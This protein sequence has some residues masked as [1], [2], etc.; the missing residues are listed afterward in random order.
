M[1]IFNEQRFA[2]NN[3]VYETPDDLFIPLMNEFHF[4]LDVCADESNAK[5][6]KFFNEEM[7]GLNQNWSGVCW[8]NPPFKEVKKWVEKAHLESLKGV[9][10]VAL[11]CAKTNTN[12]FHDYCLINE[13]RFIKG[14]PKFKGMKHGLPFPLAVVI[15]N[16]KK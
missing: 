9:T 16:S 6:A 4:T 13:V 3:Q 5:C 14:R 2:S 10:T 11:I 12:W 7:D 1:G 15:F 8:M